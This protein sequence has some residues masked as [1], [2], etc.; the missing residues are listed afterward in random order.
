MGAVLVS[1]VIALIDAVRT[2]ASAFANN[3]KWSKKIWLLILGAGLLFAVL[4]ALSMV[5]LMLNI[6]AIVP[7]AI[8]WYGIRAEMKPATDQANRN[9]LTAHRANLLKRR[10]NHNNRNNHGAR[11]SP[12]DSR[13]AG[14]PNDPRFDV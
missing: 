1:A 3:G 9:Y 14:N 12:L 11:L 10:S 2:P 5:G 4:G 8:Y 7:A 6:I 13:A